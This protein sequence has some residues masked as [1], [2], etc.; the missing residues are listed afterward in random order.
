[1]LKP[2]RL[3]AREL[4][5]EQGFRMD[6]ILRVMDSSISRSTLYNWRNNEDGADPNGTWD[7]QRKKFINDKQSLKLNLKE[8]LDIT[9]NEAKADPSS[10]NIFA[11]AKLLA[12]MPALKKIDVD[13]I[14]S[15]N[16]SGTNSKSI[17]PETLEQMKEILGL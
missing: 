10:F 4:F 14:D 16:D 13:L 17:T 12:A 1:M 3:E 8:L 9:I 7:K 15:G 5:V 11:V 6:T 2:E